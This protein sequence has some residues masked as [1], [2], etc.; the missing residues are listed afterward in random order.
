MHRSK[1][2]TAWLRSKKIKVLKWPA[3][4]PD[5][6]PIENIW[7]ILVRRIY[8]DGKQFNSREELKEAIRTAWEQLEPDVLTA[9]TNSMPSGLFQVI[10]RDG[11]ATDY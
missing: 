10:S 1:S 2:T 11:K 7:G 4:S 6:N 8:G 9:L 3:R 5:L